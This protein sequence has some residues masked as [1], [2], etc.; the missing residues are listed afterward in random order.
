LRVGKIETA[1]LRNL[2]VDANNFFENMRK[3][4]LIAI[5]CIATAMCFAQ[6]GGTTTGTTTTGAGTA[7]KKPFTHLVA[8]IGD[9]VINPGPKKKD[10]ARA[11]PG[12]WQIC[13]R[14]CWTYGHIAAVAYSWY[15]PAD[16]PCGNIAW[17]D[18]KVYFVEGFR[19]NGRLMI[20]SSGWTD[21]DHMDC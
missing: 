15:Q 18:E 9:P 21:G 17:P 1:T 13:S 14:A 8:D 5:G 7:D 3:Q 12:T 20:T 4:I 2:K 16:V 10:Y 6:S 19:L 11:T